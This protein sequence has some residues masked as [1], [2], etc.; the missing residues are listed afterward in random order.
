MFNR[1]G[2]TFLFF[3]ILFFFLAV[4][5]A[6][7][8]VLVDT[9]WVR[10]YN[11]PGNGKDNSVAVVADGSG[12]VYVTGYS[13][14]NGTGYD[15]ATIKYY[16]NGDTAWLRRWASSGS[17]EDAAYD[18]ALDNSGNVYVTGYGYINNKDYVT[19]K[20][21]S[22]GDNVWM[23]RYNFPVIDIART[24]AVDVSG[25][26]YVTGNSDGGGT[27]YDW[28]TIK[29]YPNGDTAW[30]RRYN[31]PPGT[32]SDLAND[33]A[34]DSSGNVYVTGYSTGIGSNYDYATIKYYPNGDAAWVRRYNGPGNGLDWAF[35]LAVDGYGNVYVT[36]ETYI[37]GTNYDYATIKYY[38]N[39]DTAWVRRYNGPGNDM[40]QAW[41]LAI[42]GSGNVY[43]TGGSDGGGTYTDYA[44]IKYYANGAT[45]WVR[46]YSGPSL[47]DDSQ[48]IAVDG[49][50]NV[51]VTGYSYGS[52]SDRDI[53]TI[54]YNSNG[55]M[56]WVMRYNGPLNS[57]D[58]ARAIALDS[59][60][61]VY[62]T[63]YSYGIGSDWDYATIKYAQKICGDANLDGV[64][65]I[66][67]IVYLI[68]YVFYGGSVP[69]GECDVNNDG[70]M[71]IGDIVYLINYVFYGGVEPNCL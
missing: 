20:Y 44:T 59:F 48:A 71:D 32:S 31:G 39:G 36:G 49:S 17:G 15:Y 43:V 53:A 18:L 51:Y 28:A 30:V 21:N 60:G 11:G 55:D 12:N 3:V 6:L 27:G 8:N 65:D 67:D 37:S 40:D 23:K 41:D 29:Y 46:R 47:I 16:P 9:A 22:H 13:T 33:I 52:G 34:V 62:V 50:G 14:G 25:N 68:N 24:V 54:R 38:P 26:V 56:A 63:A 2:F 35:G 61:N 64:V 45:A 7:A 42:D 57:I 1:F 10:R 69:E 58:D 70:I 19:I 66:G 4:L 5:P